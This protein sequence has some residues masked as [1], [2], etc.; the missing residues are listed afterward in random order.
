MAKNSCQKKPI[1]LEILGTKVVQFWCYT[2]L[3]KTKKLLLNWYS[4][5]IFFFRNIRTFFDIENWLWKSDL[6]TFWRPMWT[7]VKVKSK[8][9]FSFTDCFAKIKRLLTH[10]CKTPPLRS[11]YDSSPYRD[12]GHKTNK[13]TTRQKLRAYEV[14]W[15]CAQP[16]RK[17]VPIENSIAKN[18]ECADIQY[19]PNCKKV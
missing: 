3:I 17:I 10:V 13:M 4:S 2:K 9:Y 12:I 14:A 16:K 1:F 5:I 7:S 6:A 15:N 8:N 19:Q 11:H 18:E